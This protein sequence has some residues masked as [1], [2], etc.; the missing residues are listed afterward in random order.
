[1]TQ[2]PP[3]CLRIAGRRVRVQVVYPPI[4]IRNCDLV[5][6]FADHEPGDPQG[7]GAT[8]LDAVAALRD[9]VTA[10]GQPGRDC[11]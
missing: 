1:V 7:Y 9:L 11:G 2:A 3:P 6:V 5:A 10:P 4:P 8:P